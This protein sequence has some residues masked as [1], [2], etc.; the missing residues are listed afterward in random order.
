MGAI[1]MLLLMTLVLSL[2]LTGWLQGTDAYFGED[3]LQNL[4]KYL[5]DALVISGGL[6]AAAA[7]V[8]GRMERTRLVKAMVTG[9][10]ERY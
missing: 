8:M 10:K 1:M 2:G 5:A 3:W 7:I 9:V 6:H 4:H